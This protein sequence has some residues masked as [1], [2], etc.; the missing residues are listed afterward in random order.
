MPASVIFG[1]RDYRNL[2]IEQP[3]VAHGTTA[4]K[5]VASG[6]R[7]ISGWS[8]TYEALTFTPSALQTLEV[9]EDGTGISPYRKSV[10]QGAVIVPRVLFFVHEEAVTSRLGMSSGRVNYRSM[11][12][13]QEKEP[14]KSLPDLTGVIERRFIFDV[15]LGSTVTPF[16]SLD[17]WRAVLPIDRERMLEEQ[18][19]DATDRTLSQWWREATDLW[20]ENRSAASKISLWEQI[21]YQG[22]LTR[23]LGAPAQR[24]VYSKAGT[25]LAAARLNDP[26]AVIDHKLYWIPARNIDEARYLTAILNAPITTETVAGY[27]SRGLFGARDFD[28]YV[29]R[30]PIPTFDATNELHEQLVSLAQQA[31]G[32]AAQADLGGMGFQKARKVVRTALADQGIQAKLNDSVTQ[33][34]GQSPSPAT[35]SSQ[36]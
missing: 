36:R 8:A 20:E 11:R 21:D 14:W 18:Q 24:V 32:A 22:K 1:H 13:P 16:R 9:A 15:H 28:T 33:L 19:I 25:K 29:W 17:P 10:T 7:D 34:L 35:A 2:G 12:T 30:L 27:Q 31:E 26:Q 3:D 6:L 23:Q 5:L 4:T